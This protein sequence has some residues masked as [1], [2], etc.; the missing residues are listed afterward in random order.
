[1][2][3]VH[4]AE[5]FKTA[6]LSWQKVEFHLS[7]VRPAISMPTWL[8][9]EGSNLSNYWHCNVSDWQKVSYIAT[10]FHILISSDIIIMD[11]QHSNGTC[12]LLSNVLGVGGPGINF[13]ISFSFSILNTEH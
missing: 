3:M 9:V 8:K 10:P 5:Y 6:Y 11:G 12:L 4:H 1:M 7:I 2:F 13:K